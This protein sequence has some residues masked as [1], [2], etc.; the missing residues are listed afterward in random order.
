MQP[1]ETEIYAFRSVTMA[2]PRA[3]TN[4]SKSDSKC[5]QQCTQAHIGWRRSAREIILHPQHGVC[6]IARGR[7]AE[8]RK[9]EDKRNKRERK[10][11]KEET[12]SANVE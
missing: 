5:A 9:R 10:K 4:I 8:G 2:S 12:R 11:E 6:E 1:K 3:R 7:T